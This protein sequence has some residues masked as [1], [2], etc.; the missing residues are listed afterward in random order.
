MKVGSKY[1]FYIPSALGYGD[2]GAGSIIGPNA[3]LVFEVELLSIGQPQAAPGAPGAAGTQPQD[4]PP[5][6]EKPPV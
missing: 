2:R 6:E 3:P 5:A 1:K 4:Q